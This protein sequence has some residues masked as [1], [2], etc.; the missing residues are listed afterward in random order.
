M[1]AI[2][3]RLSDQNN[4]ATIE[5]F[6]MYV[7]SKLWIPLVIGGGGALANCVF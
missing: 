5:C 3:F 7:M 4:N 6:K 1:E 2:D